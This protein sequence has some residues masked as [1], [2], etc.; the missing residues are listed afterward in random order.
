MIKV[1]VVDDSPLVRDG[2][3]RIIAES[4]D[5]IISDEAAEGQEILKKIVTNCFDVILW[6]IP[7]PLGDALDILKQLK[8]LKPGLPVLILSNSPEE[9]YGLRF[10]KA[11][12]SGYMTKD[13]VP[14]EL[15]SAIRRVCDNKRYISSTFAEKLVSRLSAN[16]KDVPHGSLSDREYQIMCL[17]ASGKA[18]KEI[19]AELSLSVKTISTYRTRI[20]KKMKMKN[21]SEIT[22]YAVTQGILL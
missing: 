10:F 8:S 16:G 5:M 21:N 14:E 7:V 19:A 11:G 20:L 22:Y 4:S 6:D 2:L 9:H 17:I 12:A 18:T 3:K 1:L 13:I 15:K